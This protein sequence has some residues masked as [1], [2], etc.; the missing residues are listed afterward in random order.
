[1]R[2]GNSMFKIPRPSKEQLLP[3]LP[4]IVDL[5]YITTGGFKVVFKGTS[6]DQKLEAIKAIYIPSIEDGF[7]QEQIDQLVARAQ[8]EIGALKICNSPYVVKLAE[9]NPE[10]IATREGNYL[11][12][13]EE[14]IP[15]GSRTAATEL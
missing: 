2:R 11:L 14:F 3:Y 10:L 13:G 1:M 5:E 7:E 9:R 12:Y 6:A 4:G 8:R 15:H